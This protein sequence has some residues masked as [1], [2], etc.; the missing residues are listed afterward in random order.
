M[1]GLSFPT[2]ATATLFGMVPS[3]FLLTYMG[4]SVH[5]ANSVAIVLAGAFA[6]AFVSVPVLLHRLNWFNVRE[7][8]RWE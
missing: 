4:G 5:I 3:T 8:V 6:I 1:T 2:Y 7:L